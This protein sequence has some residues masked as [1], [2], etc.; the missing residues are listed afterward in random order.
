MILVLAEFAIPLL[1]ILAVDKIIKHQTFEEKIKLI[2]GG[3]E[4]SF[5]NIIIVSFAFTGGL[6]LLYYLMPTV[7][8]DFTWVQDEKYYND[9]AKSNGADIAQKFIENLEIV[10]ITIFKSEAIRSFL[11]IS[12]AAILLWL[13]VKKTINKTVFIAVLG[14]LILFDL[15]LVDKTYLNDKNFVNKKETESAF[16][17]TKAD[18]AVLEDT[19]PNYR[20]LDIMDQKNG[21]LIV[22]EPPIIIN[23]LV[24]TM[25]QN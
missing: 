13:F 12:V 25:P 8:S 24:V 18:K 9:F 17:L 21:P 23:P 1:A 15:A 22:Q 6:C 10:R 20:V 16:P 7:L 14:V 19:D 11:F 4:I 3:K 2:F 5:Q